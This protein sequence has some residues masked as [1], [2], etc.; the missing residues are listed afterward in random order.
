VGKHWRFR[1]EAFDVIKRFFRQG[2]EQL[3]ISYP[4]IQTAL[5]EVDNQKFTG[6]IYVNGE[7]T[8]Q[9]KVWIGS[10][11]GSQSINYLEGPRI[12]ITPDNSMNDFLT[13]DDTEGKLGIKLS[14]MGI[15]YSKPSKDIV[16]QETAAEYLWNRFTNRL[17]G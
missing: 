16:S 8:N 5:K 6:K 2:L 7:I 17:R 10:G 1:D 13:V 9:C 15:G 3:E 12:E 4:E 11:F 14:N